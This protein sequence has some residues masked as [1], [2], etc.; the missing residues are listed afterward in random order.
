MSSSILSYL[1]CLVGRVLILF[2][3]FFI[4]SIRPL[5]DWSFHPLVGFMSTQ[6]IIDNYINYITTDLI[7][8]LNQIISIKI[9]ENYYYERRQSI[10][11][12]KVQRA[13]KHW[14]AYGWTSTCI[15]HSSLHFSYFLLFPIPTPKSHLSSTQ[16]DAKHRTMHGWFSAHPWLVICYMLY[17]M[18]TI[19]YYHAWSI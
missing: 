12:C 10:N 5:I 9:L 2:I 8:L 19:L 7:T 11:R 17:G 13:T 18:K 15:T 3:L 16:N 1:V 14:F 4:H 6:Q